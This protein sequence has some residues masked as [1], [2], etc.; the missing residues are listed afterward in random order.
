LFMSYSLREV[1]ILT[2]RETDS[3]D[4][5][6]YLL[7]V[8]MNLVEEMADL[9]QQNKVD[10]SALSPFELKTNDWHIALLQIYENLYLSDCQKYKNSPEYSVGK[11]GLPNKRE[12]FS[13]VIFEHLYNLHERRVTY[14]MSEKQKR[15]ITN[16]E[17]FNYIQTRLKVA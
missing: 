5:A 3:G 17:D 8:F 7:D 4:F 16:P 10:I 11:R 13:S 15:E 1:L 12:T 9:C 6:P 2:K 14:P